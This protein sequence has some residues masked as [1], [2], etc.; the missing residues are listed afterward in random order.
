M[1]GICNKLIVYLLMIIVRYL[2]DQIF[3]LFINM[4]LKKSNS[5]TNIIHQLTH[6]FSITYRKLTGNAQFLL[7]ITLP[8]PQ[9]KIRRFISLQYISRYNLK[10]SNHM[11]ISLTVIV[12]CNSKLS[13]NTQFEKIIHLFIHFFQHFR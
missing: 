8:P 1:I 3:V 13:K 10:N 5:I 2:E 9:K 4:F 11:N 7:F 12:H 6:K